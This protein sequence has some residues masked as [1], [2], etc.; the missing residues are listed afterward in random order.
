MLA[1]LTLGWSLGCGGAPVEPTPTAGLLDGWWGAEVV[2][3]PEQFTARVASTR[4]GWIA[5]HR[6]DLGAAVA[7]GGDPAARAH[8][9]LARFYRVLAALDSEVWARLGQRW[10]DRGT[11]PTDSALPWLVGAALRDAGRDDEAATW[12]GGPPPVPAVAER[13]KLHEAV[14]AGATPRSTLD[15][16]PD[17]LLREPVDGGTRDLSDPWRLRTAARVA[18]REAERTPPLDTTLFSGLATPLPLPAP[19]ADA[20]ADADACRASV[21]PLDAEFDAWQKAAAGSA[22]SDGRALLDDL[23]LVDGARARTLVD[24]AVAALD[25]D[26]PACALALGQLALDHEAPRAIGPVNSPTLFAVIASAQL[27][28]GRTREALDAL[29]VLASGWPETAGL[30]ETLGTLV[31]L[32]GLD[33]RGDSRE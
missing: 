10:R 2:A 1:L 12:P 22:P 16:A 29:D 4:E 11:L 17:P 31:V 5:L 7:A 21:R 30:D 20:V 33:R 26:R 23:R 32:E 19:A 9:E 24:L 25:A 28:V 18:A 14:R 15:A 6:N 3:H 27:R 8:G 13:Q